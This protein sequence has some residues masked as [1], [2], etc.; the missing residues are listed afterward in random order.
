MS[1]F[2]KFIT[3][4]AKSLSEDLNKSLMASDAAT[5]TEVL[6][7]MIEEKYD[8][9]N[10]LYSAAITR[11]EKE[12]KEYEIIQKLYDQRLAAADFL[13]KDPSKEAA[14]N[15]LLSEI[16][17]MTVDV[18]REKAEAEESKHDFEETK[19]LFNSIQN[20]LLNARRTATAAMAKLDR[21]NT[22]KEY[23]KEA[24]EQAKVIS[25]LKSSGSGINSVLAEINQAAD[26]ADAEAEAAK[27]KAKLLQPCKVLEN[28]DIID[29]M[30]A[31][32]GIAT[33]TSAAERLAALK[34]K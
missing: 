6:I 13:S 16:E 12:Q 32:Q 27:R 18:E 7:D 31:S 14:L 25:G 10:E 3:N 29:A 33:P 34:A 28:Q 26:K 24:E 1:F 15:E 11:L 4:K 9:I 5:S 19:T 17:S 20:E 22:K 30:K 21:A 2:S 23:A 8:K